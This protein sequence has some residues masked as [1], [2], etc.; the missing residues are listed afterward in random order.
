LGLNLLSLTISED[1][2]N[3]IL[4]GGMVHG[5]IQ[6][7]AGGARLLAAELVN[8]GLEGGPREERADGVCF[9]DVRERIAF[10]GE[11]VDVVLQGLARLLFAALEVPGASKT[12]VC[13]L[14][15]PNE[16]LF[17]HCPATDAV[18]L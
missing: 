10:L 2:P 8:E 18:G 7:L 12:Y 6:E 1:R 11:L 16:D 9:D 3:H 17:E 13:P 14:K 5:N 15:I 4:T